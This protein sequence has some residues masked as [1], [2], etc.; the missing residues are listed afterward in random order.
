MNVDA[1][2]YK[3]DASITICATGNFWFFLRPSIKQQIDI[4][5]YRTKNLI[6]EKT[7]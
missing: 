5:E 1:D 3:S 6:F 2:L 4:R 7:P